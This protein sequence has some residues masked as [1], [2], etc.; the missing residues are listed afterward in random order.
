MNVPLTSATG[1]GRDDPADRLEREV[2]ELFVRVADLLGLP[3]SIGE[4]YGLLY[5]STEPLP[6]DTLMARLQLSK[7]ATSQGLKLLRSFGAA[8][9][10]YVPGDRR[11]HFVAETELRKLAAGFLKEKLRPHLE[12]GDERLER[13][14]A[15]AARLPASRRSDVAER[16]ARLGRW[17]RRAGLLLPT[18][19]R[20]IQT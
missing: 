20:L 11:D 16:V 18:V 12:G 6:M 2:V 3:R 4:L 7:G 5:I 10:V 17:R 19:L 13:M 15:L 1:A 14:R 8:R 9:T